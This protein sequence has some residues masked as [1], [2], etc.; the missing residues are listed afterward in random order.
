MTA[1]AAAIRAELAG[2]EDG[3]LACEIRSVGLDAESEW[4]VADGTGLRLRP[5]GSRVGGHYSVAAKPESGDDEYRSA[6]DP[7]LRR[8]VRVDTSETD[9]RIWREC[10][11]LHAADS[12]SDELEDQQADVQ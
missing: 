9:G 12:A 5:P 4:A 3:R 10:P 8:C 1:F 11:H 2:Q 7:R 6:A